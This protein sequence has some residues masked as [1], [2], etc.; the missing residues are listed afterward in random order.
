MACGFKKEVEL[1]FRCIESQEKN[2]SSKTLAPKTIRDILGVLHQILA[3]AVEDN[4]IRKKL[5]TRIK[6]PKVPKKDFDALPDIEDV[7]RLI[8]ALSY[9]RFATACELD[10]YCC[11]NNNKTDFT[12]KQFL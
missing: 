2:K 1:V 5:C 7:T 8:E 12:A 10:I 11:M 6:C 3:E 9:H 4:L